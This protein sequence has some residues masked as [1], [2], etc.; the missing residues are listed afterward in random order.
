MRESDEVTMFGILTWYKTYNYGSA[1]QAY[2]LVSKLNDLGYPSEIIH[3]CRDTNIIFSSKSEK[4]KD[5]LQRIPPALVRRLFW[6]HYQ[7]KAR[8][9][10]S[11]FED[12]IPQSKVYTSGAEIREDFQRYAAFLCGSDQIWTPSIRFLDPTYFLDFVPDS[13]GKIAYAPSIGCTYIP[14]KLMSQMKALIQRIDFLSIRETHG[15]DLVEALCNRRPEIVLD[16]TLLKSKAEWEDFA[17]K[18]DIAEPYILCYFL[19]SRKPL[20]EFALRLKKKTGYKLVVVPAVNQDL[21]WGDIRKIDAGPCEFVGLIQNA[22]YICTDSFHGTILS[23]NLEKNFFAL[24]RHEEN[25]PENQNAR[26]FHILSRLGLSFRLVTEESGDGDLDPIDYT[27]P[28]MR[29]EEERRRSL[30]FLINALD[31]YKEVE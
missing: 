31:H 19:G 24:K 12:K 27:L 23:I 9:F 10:N 8:R 30:Q 13:I 2:A 25:D 21:F 18:P 16:P 28:R 1:L 5:V 4:L 20:R 15:A 29:L 22:A 3:Y 14:D 6:K 11:F 7:R 26:L 17:A